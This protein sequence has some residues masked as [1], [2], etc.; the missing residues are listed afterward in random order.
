[1]R[2]LFRNRVFRQAMSHA[3][4]RARARKVIY[5]DQGEIT[6]GTEGP[7]IVEFRIGQGLQLYRQ[8]RDAFSQ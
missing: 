5:Y 1:M 3:Y 4:N 6:S 7:K 2:N 8:W